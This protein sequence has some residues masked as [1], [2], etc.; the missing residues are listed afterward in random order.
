[1]TNNVAI[2]KIDNYNLVNVENALTELFASIDASKLFKPNLT[3]LVKINAGVDANP[4]LAQTTHP[5]VVQ[6]VVNLLTKFGAKCII[7]DSPIKQ[8]SQNGLDK[9]YF[10]TGMLEVAN[11][12]R[13]TL[14]HNLAVCKTEIANGIKTKSATL[15]EV[16]KQVDLIVNVGKLSV[17]DNLGAL[18]VATG[19][20]GLVP[21]DIK[22]LVLNRLTT[23]EDFNNYVIDLVS[24]LQKKI[25]LNIFDGVVALEANNSQRMLSCLAVSENMFSL[26][27]VISK[28]IGRDLNDTIVKTA[29]NRGMVDFANP[30]NIVDGSLKEFCLEDFN[31]GEQTN[32]SSIHKNKGQQ[33]RF[34]NRNQQHVVICPSKCKGCSRCANICPAKAIMMKYDK[35]GELFAKIDY[36]K[37]IFCNKCYTACPYKVVDLKS[38]I[39][40]KMI[41]NNLEKFDENN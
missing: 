26:D 12:C 1:M 31:F 33:K 15:L 23:V 29:A 24:K 28:I 5:A 37:C 2:K 34:F 35:N 16:V 13:C 14:N 30:Y 39:G 10:D 17:D 19:I 20:F 36:S 40:Y 7:A 22:Q 6:A 4:D 25:V 18:G 21:G 27:A 3:V 41:I 8:Y 32:N 11:S 38:P 9:I